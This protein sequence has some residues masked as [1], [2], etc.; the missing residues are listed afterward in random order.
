MR[1]LQMKVILTKLQTT[2][3]RPSSIAEAKDLQEIHHDVETDDA[4]R[5]LERAISSGS[6]LFIEGEFATVQFGFDADKHLA[7]EISDIR[8][9]FWAI[10][11]VSELSAKRII[12]ITYKREVFSNVIPGTDQQWDAFGTPAS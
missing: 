8:D 5:L 9:G 12:D 1:Y 4:L 7:V 2:G 6:Q 3:S 10:S 11:E